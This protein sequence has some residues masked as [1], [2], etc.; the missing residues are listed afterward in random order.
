[1]PNVATPNHPLA[2]TEQQYLP[3]GKVPSPDA[4]TAPSDHKTV[5]RLGDTVTVLDVYEN[6]NGVSGLTVAYVYVH[7]TGYH[8]HL[9]AGEMGITGSGGPAALPAGQ[10]AAAS[11]TS[12]N[13]AAAGAPG[14]GPGSAGPAQQ[15]GKS[16]PQVPLA[17]PATGSERPASRPAGPGPSVKPPKP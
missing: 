9:S 14:Q 8:T 12:T 6:W 16:F 2:G 4:N 13:E 5:A 17:G 10:Q 3:A 11:P 1:M 7:A 15:A